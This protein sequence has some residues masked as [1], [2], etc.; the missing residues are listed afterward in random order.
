M[1]GRISRYG[2]LALIVQLGA[3]CSDQIS[4]QNAVSSQPEKTQARASP[5]ADTKLVVAFGDSLFA[6]YSLPQ[7][8]G[9]APTLERALEARGTKAH[10]FNAGVSGDTSAAGFQRLAFVLDGLGRK[11]DL[12]IVGLGA[13]DMLRGLS[14]D[15][16]RA[17]LD[18][19]LSELKK[20]GIKTILTG[21]LAAPNLGPDYAKAF[22]P[23]YPDLARKFGLALYPFFLADV[24]GHRERQLPDGMHPNQQ[25]VQVIVDRIRPIVVKELAG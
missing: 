5:I 10:V 9:F 11:P 20:R 6:G 15:A 24:A 4:P 8:Q 19:I 12:V 16:T 14:P 13:N 18:A 17:N 21:M 22:N 23:I 1:A 3:G 7:G 25:G 2:V